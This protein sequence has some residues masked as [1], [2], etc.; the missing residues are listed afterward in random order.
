MGQVLSADST[1]PSVK[2][3]AVTPHDTTL[4]PQTRALYVGVTGNLNLTMADG[5]DVVFSNVPVGI[6]PVQVL[7][8]KSTSTTATSIVAMY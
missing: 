7:R 3:V 8:V 1:A 5:V 4:I 6:F 2:A